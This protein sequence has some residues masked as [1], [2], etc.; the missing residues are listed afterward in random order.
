MIENKFLVKKTARY[1]V[2]KPEG[3]EPKA[4]MFAL[5]G[6]MQLAKYFTP[7]FNV[8]RDLG[9]IIVGPEALSRAYISGSEG[10]IGASWMTRE[11]RLTDIA[12]YCAYL[13]QLAEYFKDDF[14]GMPIHLLGFS[15]GAATAC[16]WFGSSQ[17]QFKSLTL[18]ASIFPPDFDFEVANEKLKQ[19]TCIM[20]IGN[21]DEYLSDEKFED[22][23]RWLKSKGVF[24]NVIK[25]EGTHEINEEVLA[26]LAK[27]VE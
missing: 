11:D 19:T 15:Q 22:Q 8:L 27:M 5:H 1:Y 26:A 3:V 4:V 12:D 17:I 7:K 16:R 24:P 18:F 9:F 2:L 20:A 10:R 25:F 13:E 23:L 6:Y 14:N 21:E